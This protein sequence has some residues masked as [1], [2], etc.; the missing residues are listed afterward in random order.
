MFQLLLAAS[1][2]VRIAEGA[3]PGTGK[4]VPSCRA[5]LN[6]SEEE[7]ATSPPVELEA[8]VTW[9]EPSAGMLFV[10]D[11]TAGIFVFGAQ[12]LLSELSTGKRISMRGVAQAGR[13]A[14]IIQVKSLSVLGTGEL[15]PAEVVNYG[16]LSSGAYDSQWVSFQGVVRH[17][18]RE[19]LHRTLHVAMGDQ[20]VLVRVQGF[21]QTPPANLLDARAEVR[22]VV[23]VHYDDQGIRTGMSLYSPGPAFVRVLTPPARERG[24]IRTGSPARLASL[25]G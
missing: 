12:T 7:L 8:V 13:Y 19:W 24:P 16:Q 6:L 25:A 18:G 3:G 2:T 9:V 22:A 15:P 4:P 10:H 1:L 11:G 23:S 21:E 5:I 14:P 20:E 17:D